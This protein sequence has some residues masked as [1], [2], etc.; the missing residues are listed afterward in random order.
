[1]VDDGNRYTDEYIYSGNKFHENNPLSK[2]NADIRVLI[3][4]RMDGQTG[5]NKQHA[6]RFSDVEIR[7]LDQNKYPGVKS[8]FK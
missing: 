1:L 2:Y 5:R 7:P 6:N 4:G 3:R 8:T